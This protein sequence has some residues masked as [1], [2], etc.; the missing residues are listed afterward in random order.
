MHGGSA[1]KDPAA[2]RSH[3]AAIVGQWNEAAPIASAISRKEAGTIIGE[4]SS[5]E[6]VARRGNEHGAS[7]RQLPL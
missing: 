7:V 3:A 6:K 4:L 5:E 2:H 1:T